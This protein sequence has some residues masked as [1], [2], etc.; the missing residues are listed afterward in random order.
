MKCS[1]RFEPPV[2]EEMADSQRFLD[3]L[4]NVLRLDFL[5]WT[6]TDGERERK[7]EEERIEYTEA[8]F[9]NKIIRKD[10]L[11]RRT[12]VYDGN[13]Y[14]VTPIV[15]NTFDKMK[16]KVVVDIATPPPPRSTFGEPIEQLNTSLT[17]PA[18]TLNL[19]L[20]EILDFLGEDILAARMVFDKYADCDIDQMTL[21][22]AYL[23]LLELTGLNVSINELFGI[24][25]TTDDA[26]RNHR[27]SLTYEA[28]L[29]HYVRICQSTA[30]GKKNL[31]PVRKIKEQSKSTTQNINSEGPK[32]PTPAISQFDPSLHSSSN[33]NSIQMA[34]SCADKESMRRQRIRILSLE[35]FPPTSLMVAETKAE[36]IEKIYP[37]T[38]ANRNQTRFHFSTELSTMAH[39]VNPKDWFLMV[40]LW[41]LVMSR[42]N[43]LLKVDS[44]TAGSSSQEAD[45][46][47]DVRMTADAADTAL[48]T[49]SSNPAVSA[50][51]E[52]AQP[53]CEQE[54][55]PQQ[56]SPPPTL[57]GTT[58][59]R[60][61][62]NA[63]DVNS[64]YANDSDKE[65]GEIFLSDWEFFV[66]SALE[67]SLF[68]AL[69]KESTQRAQ[70][71]SIKRANS[72]M[73]RLLLDE[74]RN[75]TT[76]VVDAS[77]NS[78]SWQLVISFLTWLREK[79]MSERY[80]LYKL[81]SRD[82]YHRIVS[83]ALQMVAPLS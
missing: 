36:H 2:I 78:I 26:K 79:A 23:G 4:K 57:L 22:S 54:A 15:P 53:S 20:L 74:W 65:E 77:Q 71:I 37:K 83:S 72:D 11:Q 38:L 6:V 19:S 48:D 47:V 51:A 56:P 21:W 10:Y 75:T 59:L 81:I 80:I 64:M 28:F 49:A 69:Q 25:T 41:E 70:S 17:Q 12:I 67:V 16:K 82:L 62:F 32:S 73:W 42:T 61:L 1:F 39:F 18:T 63:F 35:P 68:V 9:E 30:E 31:R 46:D 24:E 60:L 27:F 66:S 45:S 43:E 34:S 29:A 50:E 33:S 8:C 3:I 7:G 76:D 40:E 5:Y 58:K 13:I 55:E 44:K 14:V 52:V